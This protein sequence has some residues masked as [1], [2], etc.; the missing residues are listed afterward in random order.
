MKLIIRHILKT[1]VK[2]PAQ[3]T[4]RLGRHRLGL[5]LSKKPL[6]NS[7]KPI[8]LPRVLVVGVYVSSVKHLAVELC[9]E[10]KAS[11]HCEV[12]Q[13]WASIGL[14]SQDFSL[15]K[16]TSIE[17]LDKVPKFELLNSLLSGLDLSSYDYVVFTDDD[18]S[19]HPGFLDTYIALQQKLGFSISQ[20]ARSWTSSFDHSFVRQKSDLLG[21]QTRFVEIG[22]IFSFDRLIAAALIPFDLETPMGW[23]YDFVWPVQVAALGL[24]MGI[25]DKTTVDHTLRPRGANYSS[26]DAAIQGAAYVKK[27]FG[28]KSNE[29][30]VELERFP[31]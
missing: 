13:R 22:P 31:S 21:R 9:A 7:F 16:L 17:C 25:V 3:N 26:K 18:V 23:G 29:A 8:G 10:F 24:K 27:H 14:K 11:K 20:P 30:F 4:F 5:A 12:E 19:V 1:Y 28:L 15:A 6:A 2:V